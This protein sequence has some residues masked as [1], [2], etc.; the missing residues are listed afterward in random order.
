MHLEEEKQQLISDQV[1]TLNQ[2]DTLVIPLSTQ[3]T[4]HSP[5]IPKSLTDYQEMIYRQQN[6]DWQQILRSIC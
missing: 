6:L 2:K 1:V 5:V 3:N 4:Q